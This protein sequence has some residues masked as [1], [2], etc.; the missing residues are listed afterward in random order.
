M[1]LFELARVVVETGIAWNSIDIDI[2]EDR[3]AG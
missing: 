3:L 2:H 1:C